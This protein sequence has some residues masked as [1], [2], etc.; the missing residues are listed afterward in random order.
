MK[1]GDIVCVDGLPKK[2]YR[3]Q[4]YRPRFAGTQN[5]Y[6]SMYPIG[7]EGQRIRGKAIVGLYPEA[8]FKVLFEVI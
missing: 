6:L 3:V 1:E 8:R 4:V 7:V 5:A 2:R